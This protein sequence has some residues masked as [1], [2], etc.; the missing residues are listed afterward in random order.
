VVAALAA[1]ACELLIGVLSTR[2]GVTPLVATLGVN[3]LALGAVVKITGGSIASTVPDG[4]SR[5]AS[6]A[7]RC[8]YR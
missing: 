8:L 2:L 7:R 5:L 4:L 6:A 3:A 1:A